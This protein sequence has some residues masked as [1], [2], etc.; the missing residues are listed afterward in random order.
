MEDS[1]FLEKEMENIY[2]KDIIGLDGI[3]LTQ[4]IFVVIIWFFQ[5]NGLNLFKYAIAIFLPFLG[6]EFW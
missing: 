4:E 6:R 5:L 2:Q 3:M 1:H